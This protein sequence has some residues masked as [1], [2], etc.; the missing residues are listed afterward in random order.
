[1]TIIN[2][3]PRINNQKRNLMKWIYKRLIINHLL[4]N[5]NINEIEN[6][7]QNRYVTISETDKYYIKKI[8]LSSKQVFS[9]KDLYF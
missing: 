8:I 1:M 9:Y 4:I 6:L 3:K 7:L 5:I 2:A